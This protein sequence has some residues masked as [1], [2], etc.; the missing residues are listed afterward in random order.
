[1][2]VR[3]KISV[4]D[5]AVFERNADS[6]V[7]RKIAAISAVIFQMVIVKVHFAVWAVWR[8]LMRNCL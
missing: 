5:L 6:V 1:M 2:R 4:E 8:I 3:Q 7:R